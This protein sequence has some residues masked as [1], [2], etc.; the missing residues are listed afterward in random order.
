[1]IDQEAAKQLEDIKIMNEWKA[2]QAAK[3]APAPA[4]PV[5]PTA[6]DVEESG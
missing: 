6:Y 1:M 4:K 2:K 5:I 3:A